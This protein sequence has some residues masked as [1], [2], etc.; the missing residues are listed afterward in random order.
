MSNTRAGRLGRLLRARGRPAAGPRKGSRLPATTPARLSLL[1]RCVQQRNAGASAATAGWV[2]P[3]PRRTRRRR[4]CGAG[5]R[6]GGGG[7]GRG[8]GVVGGGGVV[9]SDRLVGGWP[10]GRCL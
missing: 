5:R 9:R 2:R 3:H 10:P 7:G 6:S 1:A 8:G 4:V